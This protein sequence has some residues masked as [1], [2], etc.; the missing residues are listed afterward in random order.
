MDAAAAAARGRRRVHARSVDG[1][2][3]QH[4]RTALTPPIP[5]HPPLPVY[6]IIENEGAAEAEAKLAAHASTH[7]AAI[8]AATAAR[9]EAAR[10]GDAR[11]A[12]ADVGPMPVD[13]VRP[14]LP[15][16]APAPAAVVPAAPEGAP[17]LGPATPAS[18]EAMGR[19]SGWSPAAARLRCVNEFYRSLFV[20]G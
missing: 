10:A 15:A 7:R 8:A 6:A 5:T 18:R 4:L 2:R 17:L 19:A 9:A 13:K 16:L 14:G 1:E 3:L 11:E 20:G 12:A